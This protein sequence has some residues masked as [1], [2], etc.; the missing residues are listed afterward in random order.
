MGKGYPVSVRTINVP[1]SAPFQRGWDGVSVAHRQFSGMLSLGKW[2]ILTLRHCSSSIRRSHLQSP[3]RALKAKCSTDH[4]SYSSRKCLPGARQQP[5]VA[6]TT[7]PTP[8]IR[9]LMAM[10]LGLIFKSKLSKS[11]KVE[12]IR[13]SLASKAVL[14]KCRACYNPPRQ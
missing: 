9:T 11:A 13:L 3:P 7:S 8:W 1:N 6:F 5:C 4:E 12:G 2:H 10:E 14:S